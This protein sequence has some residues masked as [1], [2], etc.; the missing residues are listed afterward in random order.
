LLLVALR[1]L[2][3][4]LL[5]LVARLL[6]ISPLAPCAEL[7]PPGFEGGVVLDHG[8]AWITEAVGSSV[9]RALAM[10]ARDRPRRTTDVVH[11]RGG[12]EGN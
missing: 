2:L 7:L 11:R 8:A 6:S 4:L 5:L 10:G 12:G 1:L 9:S 3:S